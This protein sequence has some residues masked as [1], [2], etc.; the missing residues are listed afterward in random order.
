[1]GMLTADENADLLDPEQWSKKREPVLATCREKGILARDITALPQMQREIRFWSFMPEQKKKS[2][3]TRC[4]IRIVM[5]CCV[6]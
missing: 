4:I 5:P 1:M 3:A 6:M 2:K